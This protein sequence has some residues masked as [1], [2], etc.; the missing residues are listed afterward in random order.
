[1][2]RLPI[3]QEDREGKE[4]RNVMTKE[5]TLTITEKDKRAAKLVTGLS[6]YELFGLE[7]FLAG[8]RARKSDLPTDQPKKTA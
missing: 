6:D 4:R 1:M 5:R 7:C 2:L 8:I 3:D